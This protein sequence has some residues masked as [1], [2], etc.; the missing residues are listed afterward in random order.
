M[1]NNEGWLLDGRTWFNDINKTQ[2]KT[3]TRVEAILDAAYHG[4]MGRL[5]K[6]GPNDEFESRN[7]AA[8]ESA[9]SSDACRHLVCF[10]KGHSV[11]ALTVA[12]GH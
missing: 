2:T 3:R 7:M 10:A 4:T 9:L 11:C 5:R 8:Y 12:C 6:R 1:H